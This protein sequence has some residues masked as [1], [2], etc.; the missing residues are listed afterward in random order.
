MFIL[1]GQDSDGNSDGSSLFVQLRAADFFDL[2]VF[3]HSEI[4]SK[5]VI[6]AGIGQLSQYPDGSVSQLHHLSK[7][8]LSDKGNRRIIISKGYRYV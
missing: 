8:K 5:A 3:I 4:Q 7:G 1:T 2:N 6:G